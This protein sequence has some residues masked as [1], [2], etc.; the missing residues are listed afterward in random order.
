MELTKKRIAGHLPA[1]D[2][3]LVRPQLPPEHPLLTNI[4]TWAPKLHR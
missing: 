1:G 2:T 3:T 4:H